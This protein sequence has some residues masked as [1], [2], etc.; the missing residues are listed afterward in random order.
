LTNKINNIGQRIG[1]GI[2]SNNIREGDQK[3]N[4]ININCLKKYI[5]L[6]F[7]KFK[8]TCTITMGLKKKII[9]T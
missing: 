1:G 5:F 9:H 4:S 7:L 2:K 6:K 3:Q 8:N